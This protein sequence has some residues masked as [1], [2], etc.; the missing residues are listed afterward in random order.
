MWVHYLDLH[1][2]FV[3]EQGELKAAFTADGIHL[4]E[5]AYD[6]WTQEIDKALGRRPS[7]K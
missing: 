5:P 7:G 6:I 1:P 2:L 4:T 3:N